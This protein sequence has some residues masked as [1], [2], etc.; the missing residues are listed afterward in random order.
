M[1]KSTYEKKSITLEMAKRIIEA[2]ENKAE[3]IGV[4]MVIAIVDESGNL[5]ALSRMDRAALLAIQVAQDKA[6]TRVGHTH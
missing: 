6:Y 1:G 2:A 5:K 3:E 4:P